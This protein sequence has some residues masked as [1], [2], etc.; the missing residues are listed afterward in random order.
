MFY[1]E[2]EEKIKNGDITEEDLV[3]ITGYYH[4]DPMMKPTRHV[5]PILVQITRNEMTQYNGSKSFAYHFRPCGKSGKLLATAI[6]PYDNTP[7]YNDKP[8]SLDIFITEEE[9]RESYAKSAEIVKDKLSKACQTL[10]DTF[11]ARITE[12]DNRI[13]KNK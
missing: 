4:N 6:F 12:V 11:T 13:A 8:Y 7:D 3:W 2:L 5:A 9:A 1:P 10:V